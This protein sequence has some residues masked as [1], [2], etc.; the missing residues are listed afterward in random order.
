[1]ASSPAPSSLEQA[2]AD[3]DD[4]EAVVN[5][6][7]A[8]LGKAKENVLLGY[9][10]AL[11]KTEDDVDAFCLRVDQ[12]YPAAQR[13]HVAAEQFYINAYVELEEAKKEILRLRKALKV[14]RISCRLSLETATRAL[15]PASSTASVPN[16]P[17]THPPRSV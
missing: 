12:T 7:I 10:L 5:D 1:M 6:L 2:K 9:T 14:S 8:A 4:K 3:C 15:S 16:H 13:S 11:G 17:I